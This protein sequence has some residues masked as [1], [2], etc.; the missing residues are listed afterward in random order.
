M[1]SCFM[2]KAKRLTDAYRFPGFKPQ[3]II[4]GVFGDP[5]ARVIK[6]NWVEKKHV[7]RNAERSIMVFMTARY[8]VSAIFHA[9]TP[10]STLSWKSVALS[11]GVVGK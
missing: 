2:K 10:G 1:F 4:V 9:A 11:V 6:L 8:A 5:R 3:Q 7:V